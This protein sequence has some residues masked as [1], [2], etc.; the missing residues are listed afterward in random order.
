MAN[1]GSKCSNTDLCMHGHE[2]DTV[3]NLIPVGRAVF[4]LCCGACVALVVSVGLCRWN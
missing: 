1:V 2:P 3:L 4:F